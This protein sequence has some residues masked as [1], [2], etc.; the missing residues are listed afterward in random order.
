MSS[1]PMGS[2]QQQ[3]QQQQQ[4]QAQYQYS[5][6]QMMGGS[7]SNATMQQQL[8]AASNYPSSSSQYANQ[9]N[10][11]YMQSGAQGAYLANQGASQGIGG[12]TLATT[13]GSS[14]DAGVN[15]SSMT[16]TNNGTTLQISN[17][18]GAQT[19]NFNST[20]STGSDNYP[21][22][23]QQKLPTVIQPISMEDDLIPDLT[24][25]SSFDSIMTPSTSV[26][27][28]A[29]SSDNTTPLTLTVDSNNLQQSEPSPPLQTDIPSPSNALDEQLKGMMGQIKQNPDDKRKEDDS[30]T[31]IEPTE[32]EPISIIPQTNLDSNS[33][34]AT[35]GATAGSETGA[36]SSGTPD[37]AEAKEAKEATPTTSSS[38]SEPDKSGA[39]KSKSQEDL[40]TLTRKKRGRPPKNSA[41]N[42]QNEGSTS[43]ASNSPAASVTSAESVVAAVIEKPRSSLPRNAKE[44]KKALVIGGDSQSDG[45]LLDDSDDGDWVP[46]TVGSTGPKLAPD[47]RGPPAVKRS[48]EAGKKFRCEICGKIFAFQSQFQAHMDKHQME[49]CAGTPST[50][51]SNATPLASPSNTFICQVCAESFKIACF[52]K[53][54][55]EHSHP[56]VGYPD[57]HQGQDCATCNPPP[58]PSLTKQ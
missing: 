29:Q 38:T 17:V 34:P 8:Q 36:P 27:S 23:T 2:S 35:E 26:Q 42:L 21:F 40:P 20:T 49:D 6:Q 9:Y 53:K 50:S 58:P 7:Y 18:Q 48:K 5:Q 15:S 30:D 16:S 19:Q 22:D 37:K 47:G 46:G 3:Q 45:E 28:S 4:Q 24:L 43:Q 56:G 25:S 1:Y 44:E 52:F 14:S 41:N 51:T 32:K 12:M 33:N 31:D 11:S 39:E 54:H 57:P 55:M 10:Q 13:T